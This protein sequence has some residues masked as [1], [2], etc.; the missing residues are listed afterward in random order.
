MTPRQKHWWKESSSQR[1]EK[2]RKRDWWEWCSLTKK[3]ES[4]RWRPSENQRTG[5]I[6]LKGPV[7]SQKVYKIFLPFV[8][9]SSKQ[10]TADSGTSSFFG[11]VGGHFNWLYWIDT[12]QVDRKAEGKSCGK[13][14]QVRLWTWAG[15][16]QLCGIWSPAHPTEL[17]QR[18]GVGYILDEVQQTSFEDSIDA[19]LFSLETKWTRT[20]GI[21]NICTIS[22]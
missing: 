22:I 21:L 7:I 13:G 17:S 20:S 15:H 18:A 5:I 11:W 16:F 12:P 6:S 9:L 14:P 4:N 2:E 19:P 10:C 1:E 8:F 3:G